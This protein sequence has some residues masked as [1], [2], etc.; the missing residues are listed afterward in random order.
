[1]P[2]PEVSETVWSGAE[3]VIVTI[4]LEPDPLKTALI[5]VP[6]VNL[7]VPPFDIWPVVLP[8]VM[9]KVVLLEY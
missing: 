5:P 7:S 1:M 2:V 3:F 6:E 8:S 9:E 4:E